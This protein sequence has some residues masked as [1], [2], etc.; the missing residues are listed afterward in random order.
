MITEEQK[1]ISGLFK[2]FGLALFTPIGSAFFQLL[3]FKKSIFESY[4]VLTLLASLIGI[5]FLYSGYNT[6]K[7]TKIIR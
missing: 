3:L 2:T 7:E 5:L 4:L 1:Y 6:I